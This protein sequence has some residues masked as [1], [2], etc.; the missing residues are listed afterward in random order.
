MRLR[1]SI[2]DMKTGDPVRSEVMG[3]RDSDRARLARTI[4]WAVNNGKGVQVC[5][6]EDEGEDNEQAA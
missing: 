6:V 3:N 1:V 5:N 2:F 4:A